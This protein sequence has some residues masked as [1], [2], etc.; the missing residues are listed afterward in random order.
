M[1]GKEYTSAELIQAFLS[2]VGFVVGVWILLEAIK[3]TR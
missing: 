1:S 3:L 2:G